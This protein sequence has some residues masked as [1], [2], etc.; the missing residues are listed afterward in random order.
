MTQLTITPDIQKKKAVINGTIACGEHVQV[1]V[2]GM[3]QHLTNTLRLRVVFGPVTV[4]MFP[5]PPKEGETASQ[6]TVS[7]SDLRCVLNLNTVQAFKMCLGWQNDCVFVL[8]DVGDITTTP[9]ADPTLYFVQPKLVNGWPNRPEIQEL[10]DVD[11]YPKLIQ[12]DAAAASQLSILANLV[13]SIQSSLSAANAAIVDLTVRKAN[14]A[15][16]YTKNEVGSLI[17]IAS[18]PLRNLRFTLEKVGNVWD[19]VEFITKSLGG[20]VEGSVN[21]SAENPSVTG[22][23]PGADGSVHTMQAMYDGDNWVIV[24]DPTTSQE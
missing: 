19:V 3:A 10:L 16:I 24:C 8:E 14:V 18:K 23:V 11:V 17:A 7:G 21:P 1:T 15:D 5:V 13:S 2:S 4:A 6:W 12:N 9:P 22:I 20:T